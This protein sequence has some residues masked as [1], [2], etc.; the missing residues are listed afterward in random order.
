MCG[1]DSDFQ[2]G[3]TALMCAAISGHADCGQLLIDAG[4]DKDIMNDVRTGRCFA[5]AGSDLLGVLLFC[6]LFLCL[7][8]SSIS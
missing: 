5:V 1:G 3:E 8:G 6:F 2:S 7:P 4:A